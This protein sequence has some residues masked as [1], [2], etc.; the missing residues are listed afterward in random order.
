M[1]FIEADV[2]AKR[3]TP[4][5]A[6]AAERSSTMRIVPMEPTIELSVATMESHAAAR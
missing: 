2:M 6:S 4:A 5:E 3:L 1:S